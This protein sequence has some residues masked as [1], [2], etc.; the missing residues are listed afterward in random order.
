MKLNR[1]ICVFALVGGGVGSSVQALDVGDSAPKLSIA[2]WVQGDSVDLPRDAAKRIHMVEFWAVWCP[3]CKE[4]VPLLNKLQTRYKDQVAI[5]GVTAPDARG[6]SPSAVRK[7][8]KD[9]G[10]NMTYRVALDDRDQTT[11]AYLVA[12]GALGIPHAFLIGKDGR[13]AWQGSPLDPQLETVIEGLVS[14]SYDPKIEA[15][16]NRRF[17][18]LDIALRRGQWE[19]V[20]KGLADILKMAPGHEMALRALRRVYV[21]EMNKPEDFKSWARAH[22]SANRNNARAMQML[23]QIVMETEDLTRRFPDISLESARAAYEASKTKDVST[24]SVYALALYQIGALD[25]AITLQREAV[26]LATG[27]ERQQAQALYDFFNLCK[28]L[29]GTAQ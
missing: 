28:Q 14:G 13:I 8:V 20:S 19:V 15:E 7:F 22:I 12:A 27:D 29:Q 11:N 16:V 3:P 25:R 26:D 10:S 5:I 4:S 24:I 9:Q 2:E 1:A 6:N 23:A 17:Q 21:E 18:A